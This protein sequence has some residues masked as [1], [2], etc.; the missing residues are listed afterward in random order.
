MNAAV[1][2]AKRIAYLVAALI[3]GASCYHEDKLPAG[4]APRA[5][6]APVALAQA[7]FITWFGPQGTAAG[8]VFNRQATGESALWFIADHVSPSTVIVFAG[9]RLESAVAKDLSHVTATVPEGLYARPGVYH[10]YLLDAGTGLQSAP[11]QF[12]V[13]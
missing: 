2:P 9:T 4:S 11:V 10:V 8:Q 6:T 3:L 13:R 1:P 12:T 7:P 5:A